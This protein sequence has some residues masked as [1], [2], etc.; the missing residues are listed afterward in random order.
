M[1]P[2]CYKAATASYLGVLNIVTNYVKSFYCNSNMVESESEGFV[3]QFD[4]ILY[5]S[6]VCDVYCHRL[7]YTSPYVFNFLLLV[8]Y[9]PS[10]QTPLNTSLTPALI[11]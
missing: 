8:N 5:I 1:L 9:T 6:D 11:K 10:P 7:V 4:N 3:K 2:V